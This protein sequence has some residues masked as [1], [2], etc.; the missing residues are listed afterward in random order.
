M[1]LRDCKLTTLFFLFG[2]GACTATQT[3]DDIKLAQPLAKGEG[4]VLLADAY[5]SVVTN[6][7]DENVN[8]CLGDGIR[9][10]NPQ[11]R[12]VPAQ[13]FRTL[14]YPYFS[15]STSPHT[16]EEY[17]ALINKP[18]IRQ[19]IARLGVRYLVVSSGAATRNDSHGGIL[20]GGGYGGAGCLGM[21]WYDRKTEFKAQIW[22]LKRGSLDG[23]IQT[24]STGTGVIPALLLPFP[25]YMPATESASCQE[26]GVRLGNALTRVP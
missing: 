7:L 24:K 25:V 15:T 2:L 1:N 12:I 14:L 26:L 6:D 8:E 3:H 10:V 13:T 11:L 17:Q 20:C 21:A 9:K 22:D 19:R 4:V 18:L 23:T 16:T 5:F